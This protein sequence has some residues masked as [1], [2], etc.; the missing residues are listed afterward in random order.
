[1]NFRL[2]RMNAS[3]LELVLHWRNH[4]EVLRQSGNQEAIQMEDHRHWFYRSIDVRKY[5]FEMNE[6]PIGV[7]SFKELKEFPIPVLNLCTTSYPLHLEWSFYL[8]QWNPSA[9]GAGKL[10]LQASLIYLRSTISDR[11]IPILGQVRAE[12]EKSIEVHRRLGFSE[13]EPSP[14]MRR[15]YKVLL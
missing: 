14:T 3:D 13:I 10:M 5:V 8:D 11:M 6:N 4:P 12:N 15:F 1:M 2:R 9:A 7:V